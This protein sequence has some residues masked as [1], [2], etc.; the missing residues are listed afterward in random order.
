MLIC[1][2]CVLLVLCLF[3]VSV[4]FQFPFKGKTLVIITPDPDHC[5][6]FSYSQ[7]LFEFCLRKYLKSSV[8]VVLCLE[9]FGA[10]M[11]H[12]QNW[13]LSQVT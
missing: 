9:S 6:F 1:S 4:D 13:F 3:V 7:T 8:F 11:M 2:S 10:P 5:Y 12:F